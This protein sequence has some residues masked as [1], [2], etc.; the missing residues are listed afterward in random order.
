MKQRQTFTLSPEVSLRAKR[1]ARRHGLSLSSL[2]EDLLREKT[3]TK[4]AGE[5]KATKEPSFSQRWA[6][7]GKL[8]SKEDQRAQRLREKYKL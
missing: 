2:V 3:E 5:G 7:K 1:Y 4:G 6:A 8:S